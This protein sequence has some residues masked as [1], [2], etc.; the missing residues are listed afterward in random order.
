M[1]ESGVSSSM[2][3]RRHHPRCP[4]WVG[5][6]DSVLVSVTQRPDIGR[7][8]CALSIG[9]DCWLANLHEGRHCMGGVSIDPDMWQTIP[10]SFIHLKFQLQPTEYKYD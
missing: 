10:F 4:R 2:S 8:H 7:P 6:S 5:T 1:D 3:P 9:L